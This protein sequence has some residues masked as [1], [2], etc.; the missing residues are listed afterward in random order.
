M[1]NWYFII[2]REGEPIG[3][4]YLRNI[5]EKK[6]VA[7]PGILMRE[8]D[9]GLMLPAAIAMLFQGEVGFYLFGLSSLIAHMYRSH[10]KSM[11]NH[12]KIGAKIL[13]E[14]GDN[15]VYLE[16]TR[17]CN[18]A[19]NEKLRRALTTIYGERDYIKIT[20]EKEKDN[21]ELIQFIRT[22]LDSVE[23]AHRDKFQLID[24]YM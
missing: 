12:L 13:E 4:V 9:K 17:N 2:E 3:A 5:D 16:I 19:E 10:T 1:N 14:F 7:E 18:E 8:D 6:G 15:S 21:P 22:C 24:S 23:E 20:I 11:S